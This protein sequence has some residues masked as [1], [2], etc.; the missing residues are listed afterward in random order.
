MDGTARPPV[1]ADEATLI[2]RSVERMQRD[3][4]LLLRHIAGRADRALPPAGETSETQPAKPSLLE[5]LCVDAATLARSPA[6]LD[7]LARC[8][9]ALTREAAP[10]T[11][12]S[13]RLTRTYLRRDK[14][15]SNQPDDDV[16][17]DEVKQR[18]RR[19]RHVLLGLAFG[20][21]G[22]VLLT[23]ALL[24]HV[25]DGRRS[26]VQLHAVRTELQATYAE[27]VGLPAA[28]WVPQKAEDGTP[29]PRFAHVCG[30]GSDGGRV[31]AATAEGARANGL[32][33]NAYEGGLRLDLVLLRIE[34]WN[35]RTRR[36]LAWLF[37]LCPPH[38]GPDGRL[39]S[40]EAPPQTLK[41]L[42][43]PAPRPSEM[44]WSRTEI[45]LQATIATLSGF[46]LPLLT[47]FIGGA[48]YVL[49]R[50]DQKLSSSTLEPR[51]GWHAVLRVLLATTL[52]GL[53]G[54]VWSGDAVSLGGVNL[55]LAAAAFFVGFA[56]EAVF[57]L[58]EAMVES[59]AGRL[60]GEPGPPPR[61]PG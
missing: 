13:V 16:V 8:L 47:G 26:L 6:Q 30:T 44:D 57:T 7:R 50:L 35:C 46:V 22:I 53:I 17:S 37:G 51:D 11:A 2:L 33:N 28:A 3:G 60:R 9:D 58:I 48:A 45:R 27:L 23:L 24:A 18:A 40:S 19:L 36:P 31:P 59:V 29:P 34:G 14:P 52:G 15:S 38:W 43:D 49:R 12:A 1:A 5:T 39:V 21:M 54:V 55:S 20:T 32:C 4:R 56:L 61:A 42:P 25:D 10:A 41:P